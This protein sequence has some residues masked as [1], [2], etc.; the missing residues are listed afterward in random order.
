M[1]SDRY[2]QLLADLGST[3]RPQREWAEGRGLLLIAGHFA[4]GVGAGTWLFSWLFDLPL[5]LVVAV[6]AVAAGGLAHLLFLGRPARFWRMVRARRSWIAR[7]FFGMILFTIGAVPYTVARLFA[8]A[9]LRAGHRGIAACLLLSL[10]GAA[11]LV[12]YKGNVYAASRG[13]PFWN[14][15]IL[16]LLYIAYALRGGVAMLLVLL[17]AMAERVDSDFV[18]LIE[19]WIAVS[20]AVM[21]TFYLTVMRGTHVAARRSV[22]D[23]VAGRVSA[24]FYL[25]TIGAGL[26]LPILIGAVGLVEPLSL[27]S[28][29]LVGILSLIGDFFAKLTI[30]RAG[31]YVPVVPA[32]IAAR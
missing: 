31:V 6:L 17:P 14:S 10:L 8:D 1:A 26:A 7:G 2:D 16:P 12:V 18:A 21:V 13:V 25:G 28:L 19:L 15:P 24:P 32:G 30:A 22:S 23:L 3:F 5:G 11:I 9:E 29:A 27:A 4:S 20:A